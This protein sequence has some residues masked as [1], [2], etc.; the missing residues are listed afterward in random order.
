MPSASCAVLGRALRPAAARSRCRSRPRGGRQRG[1][2]RRPARPAPPRSTARVEAAAARA[3]RA[4]ARGSGRAR[5]GAGQRAPASASAEVVGAVQVPPALARVWCRNRGSAKARERG[6]GPPDRP[7]SSACR[8]ADSCTLTTGSPPPAG[9][10][11]GRLLEAQV[12]GG[13]CPGTRRCSRPATAASAATRRRWSP[14]TQP[15]SGSRAT[16]TERPVASSQ[17]VQL[18]GQLGQRAGRADCGRGLVEAGAPGQRQRGDRAPG[19]VVG[20]QAGEHPGQ[21]DG[22]VQPFAGR[23]SPAGRPVLDHRGVE[24]LV[25]EAVEGD[26]L[27]AA[28][29]PARGAAGA[30][31]PGRRASCAATASRASHSPTPRR[32]GAEPAAHRLA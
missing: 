3:R 15:G 32:V 10:R 6:R 19:G 26:H 25:G 5:A 28:R 20:Q 9:Q 24:A 27:Q 14:R 11:R 22:V 7:G 31:R 4:A 12:A 21:V 29:G 30:A 17:L 23:S 8:A 16:R 1:A 13:R 2:G 18:P